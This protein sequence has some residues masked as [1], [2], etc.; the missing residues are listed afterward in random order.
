M[1]LVAIHAV[2][3]ISIYSAVVGIRLRFA[4]AVRALEYRIIIG[5]DV[6]RRAHTVG[7]AVVDGERSVLNMIECSLH[8]IRRVVTRGTS[9]REELRLCCVAGIA[10]GHVIRLMAAIAVGRKRG[11]IVVDVTIGALARR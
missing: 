8:P 11:V 1:A 4:V 6:A 3:D 5:V 10:R 7:I 2:V 9:G